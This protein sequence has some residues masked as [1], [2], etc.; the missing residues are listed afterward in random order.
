MITF[1]TLL[2]LFRDRFIHPYV[3]LVNPLAITKATIIPTP[4]TNPQTTLTQLLQQ[5][6]IATTSITIASDS[7]LLVILPTKQEI[8]FSP[9]KDIAQQISSLQLIT[10]QLTIEG[11]RFT[12]VDLRFDNPVVAF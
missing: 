11:R 3:S 8:I 1:G 5:A 10:K 2:A 9:T 6:N 12:S 4:T 7:S